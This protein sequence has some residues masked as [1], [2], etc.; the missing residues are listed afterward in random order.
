MNRRYGGT[1]LGLAIVKQL[2]EIME[3]YVEVE[4]VLGVGSKFSVT[5]PLPLDTSYEFLPR[6]TDGES[7]QELERC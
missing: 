1:G 3:G 6:Q 2:V 7:L 4:S 5:L